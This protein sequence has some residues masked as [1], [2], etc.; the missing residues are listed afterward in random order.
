MLRLNGTIRSV[1]VSLE[2]ISFFLSLFF[3]FSE[4][5][6]EKQKQNA[7]QWL[8]DK[9]P[10]TIP[11]AS[12]CHYKIWTSTHLYRS[13]SCSLLYFLLF[14]PL[15]V[16]VYFVSFA[17]FY[18]TLVSWW[19]TCDIYFVC[20]IFVESKSIDFVVQ[21]QVSNTLRLIAERKLNVNRGNLNCE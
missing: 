1:S 13:R 20:L 5:N 17:T 19:R 2:T 21:F 11:T 14:W 9:W 7:H 15:C 16:C 8:P 4:N 18:N 12:Y 6:T 3:F 10:F